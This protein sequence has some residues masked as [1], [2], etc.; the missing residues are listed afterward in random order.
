VFLIQMPPISIYKFLCGCRLS[1]SLGKNLKAELFRRN[2][3]TAFQRVFSISHSI[4]NILEFQLFNILLD[5]T[6]NYQLLN[7]YHSS[8]CVVA[9][10]RISSCISLMTH[11]TE[12]LFL[13]LLTA[14]N[15]PYSRMF[16]S[17]VH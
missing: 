16:K 15:I 7:F 5:N 12:H 1:F 10:M 13:H 8:E 17:S 3:Q 11:D 4:S 9:S 6:C 2:C 14:Q